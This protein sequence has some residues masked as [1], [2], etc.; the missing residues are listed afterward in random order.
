MRG[1]C[2]L[3]SVY[4]PGVGIRGWARMIRCGRPSRSDEA[5]RARPVCESGVQLLGRLHV[6]R[7]DAPALGDDVD[8]QGAATD[9]AVLD[10][11]LLADRWVDEHG[12]RFPAVRARKCL[13]ADVHGVKEGGERM[14]SAGYRR[15]PGALLPRPLL[16]VGA[17]VW[18]YSVGLLR[19]RPEHVERRAVVEAAAVP[20]ANRDGHHHGKHERPE[21][22]ERR[23]HKGPLEDEVGKRPRARQGQQ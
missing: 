1:D 5:E 10:V 23:D 18:I 2:V 9:A 4:E 11:G 20:E 8:A 21:K 12:G 13:L 15:T 7:H 6:E 22:H 16:P 19:L 14:A 17:S 3:R